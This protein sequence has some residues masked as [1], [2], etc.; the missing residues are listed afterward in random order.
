METYINL[1]LYINWI[2]VFLYNQYT[3]HF[4]SLY[5]CQVD[6]KE[7]YFGKTKILQH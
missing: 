4:I 1:Y 5:Y 6:E 2:V 7:I 3:I